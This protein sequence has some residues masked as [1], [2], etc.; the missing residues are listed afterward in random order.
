MEF[1]GITKNGKKV[2]D[3]PKS[4]WHQSV[5]RETLKKALKKVS[6]EKDFEK[7]LVGFPTW[8]GKS[9]CVRV[10]H[11]KD[12][13][14]NVIRKGAAGPTPMVMGRKA[15]RSKTMQIILLKDKKRKNTYI[16]I[17]AFVGGWSEPEP[18]DRN[19]TE[20]SEE[21]W[22]EHALIYNHSQVEKVI[23]KKESHK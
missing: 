11:S 2:F 19:K 8:I 15:E 9:W 7:F 10:D 20:K 1:I 16:L 3:R 5:S 13:I 17:S 4:Q 14:I 22:K 12:K 6:P 21:F 18:W 23:R